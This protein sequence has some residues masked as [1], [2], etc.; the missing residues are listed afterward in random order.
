MVADTPVVGVIGTLC[1]GAAVAAS[2]I[3]SA[4]SLS[5]ISPSN[6]SP[7]LTSD[8][9]GNAGPDNHAGYYRVANNDLITAG[10][11]A[12]FSY[13]ALGLRKMAAIH[14]GDAYTSALA[15]AFSV[16]FRAHGGTVPSIARVTRGQTD[17]AGFLAGLVD[18]EP[19][20]VFFPLFP[21][22]ADY[23]IRQAAKL[24]AFDDVKMIGGAATLTSALL[25]L[26]EAEGLYF[27]GP[28]PGDVGNTNQ[29]TGRSGAEVLAAIEAAF[30]GPPT[31]ACWA[32]AYGATTMLLSAIERVAV[33]DGE[34]LSI[35]RAALRAA[36]DRTAGF[37]GLIGMLSCDDFGDCGTGRAAIRLHVDSSAPDPLP[38]PVVYRGE[39]DP[40]LP[41]E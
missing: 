32:H 9:A 13:E 14:D 16:A 38:L 27:T 12:K 11:V 7:Q 19:D 21:A 25:A 33:L 6:T 30:R 8:L 5:T 15:N 37:R 31:S 22:E 26:P 4:A 28:D 36:V 24:D 20:G 23:V 10:V 39:R 3:L 40:N 2:P 17:M 34:T 29:A 35:D 41:P 1:S 18:A